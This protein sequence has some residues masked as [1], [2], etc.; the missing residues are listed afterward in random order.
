MRFIF[1]GLVAASLSSAFTVDSAG[2]RSVL[3]FVAA[4]SFCGFLDCLAD[5]IVDRQ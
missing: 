3:V 4:I 5:R 1:A 2:E